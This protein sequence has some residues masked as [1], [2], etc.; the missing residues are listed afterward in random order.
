VLGA[1]DGFLG[2]FSPDY[3]DAI[4]DDPLEAAAQYETYKARRR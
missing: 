4:Y 3:Y 2:Q 1:R